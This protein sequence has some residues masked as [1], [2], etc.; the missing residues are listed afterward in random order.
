MKTDF[1]VKNMHMPSLLMPK[2]E[3]NITSDFSAELERVL[4]TL[5]PLYIKLFRKNVLAE[6]DIKVLFFHKVSSNFILSN[7]LHLNF[8]F[9]T[10]SCPISQ[11]KRK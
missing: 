1:V 10:C 5:M 3:K 8:L 9:Y 7:R 11:G 4:I 2:D 6:H